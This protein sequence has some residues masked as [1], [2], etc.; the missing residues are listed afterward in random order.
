MKIFNRNNYQN[1]A[2]SRNFS[3]FLFAIIMISLNLLLNGE[4]AKEN[5]SHHLMYLDD[6][7]LYEKID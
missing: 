5:V 2:S 4:K 6:L 1:G 3:L 7:K